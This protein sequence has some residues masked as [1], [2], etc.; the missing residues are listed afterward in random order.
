MERIGQPCFDQSLGRRGSVPC[1]EMIKAKVGMVGRQLLVEYGGGNTPV[2]LTA[3]PPSFF[4][5][6]EESGPI[7]HRPDLAVSLI[8][9]LPV[10]GRG[11]GQFGEGI[12]PAN[13][14]P[15]FP[16]FAVGQSFI[17]F[18]TIPEDFC[19]EHGRTGQYPA[20]QQ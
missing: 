9:M 8:G 16:V 15:Q 3:Q 14:Q 7:V 12:L 19:P 13:S 10:Q 1:L 4:G 5:L 20:V 18:P 6:S 17:K 11:V 2:V